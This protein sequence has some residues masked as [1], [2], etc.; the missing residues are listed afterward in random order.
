MTTTPKPPPATLYVG[1]FPH[2]GSMSATMNT[3]AKA[4]EEADYFIGGFDVLEYRLVTK[5]R[6]SGGKNK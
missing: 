3:F 6:A 2:D 5:P 1:F 4:Y